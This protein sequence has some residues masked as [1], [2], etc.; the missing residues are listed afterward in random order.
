[1]QTLFKIQQQVI[2]RIAVI[3]TF[4]ALGMSTTSFSTSLQDATERLRTMAWELAAKY[5]FV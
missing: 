2:E 5:S 3:T 4:L 1:M